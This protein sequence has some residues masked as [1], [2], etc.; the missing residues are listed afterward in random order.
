MNAERLRDDRG[1]TLIELLITVIIMGIAVAVLIGGIATSIR[2]TDIHR[3]QAV[4]GAA[5]RDLAEAIE[6]RVAASPT[7]YVDCAGPDAYRASY[8][9]PAGYAHTLAV[10]YWDGSAFTSTCGG[11]DRALQRLRLTVSSQDGR[12]SESLDLVIRRPCRPTDPAC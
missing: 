4:A 1:D 5:V 6:S 10:T 3:K 12:A 11:T 9:P 2:I 7:G 8:T